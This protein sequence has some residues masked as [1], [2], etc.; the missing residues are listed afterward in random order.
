MSQLRGA[1]P[2]SPSPRLL[3]ITRSGTFR[4]LT[5]YPF[6]RS[7]KPVEGGSNGRTPNDVHSRAAAN[8]WAETDLKSVDHAR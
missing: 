5:A 4:M 3:P 1:D 7:V 2:L 6:A 8:S